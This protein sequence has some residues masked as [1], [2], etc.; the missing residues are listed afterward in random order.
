MIIKAV[1]RASP[2]CPF[3]N[4]SHIYVLQKLLRNT[5][6]EDWHRSI[7]FFIGL[8]FVY[9][10]LNDAANCVQS[11]DTQANNLSLSFFFVLCW[12]L[13]FR[14]FLKQTKTKIKASF[15]SA[16]IKVCKLKRI[17]K[18]SHSQWVVRVEAQIEG[19]KTYVF[20][21]K[22]RAIRKQTRFALFLEFIRFV[23]LLCYFVVFFLVFDILRCTITM[24]MAEMVNSQN[25]K[26]N[27]SPN[28]IFTDGKLAKIMR[29]IRTWSATNTGPSIQIDCRSNQPPNFSMVCDAV[30]L[31][32]RK[33]FVKWCIFHRFRYIRCMLIL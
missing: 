33:L 1:Y 6:K 3:P 20:I 15:L 26:T 9:G 30:V 5:I 2:R 14:T 11:N 23:V 10:T 17:Q 12:K 4:R 32:C 27:R 22:N 8:L 31:Q 21:E 19:T 25:S 13:H 24:I 7:A 29:C 28:H 18:E 16:S